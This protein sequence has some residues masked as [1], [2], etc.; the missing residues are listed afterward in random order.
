MK[1]LFRIVL[2]FVAIYLAIRYIF[3]IFSPGKREDTVQ[4][5]PRK[6]GGRFDE[7]RISEANFKDI[8]DKK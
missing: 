1:T 8:T 3:R 7:E 4:G 6:R 5:T 2:L